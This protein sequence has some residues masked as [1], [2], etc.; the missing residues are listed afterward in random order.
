MTLLSKVVEISSTTRL[1]SK[2]CGVRMRDD[3]QRRSAERDERRHTRPPHH[4]LQK[5]RSTLL[6]LGVIV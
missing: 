5:E 1:K 4:N 2:K 3:D 6:Q